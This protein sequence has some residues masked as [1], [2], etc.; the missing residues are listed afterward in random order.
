MSRRSK[1]V[2]ET[3]CDGIARLPGAQTNGVARTANSIDGLLP[4]GRRGL[5]RQQRLEISASPA[6]PMNRI[7]NVLL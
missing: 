5:R 4:D 1:N 2:E 6:M 3:P 7:M